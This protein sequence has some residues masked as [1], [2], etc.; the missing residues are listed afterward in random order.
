MQGDPLDVLPTELLASVLQVAPPTIT[1]LA[2]SVHRSTDGSTHVL[3][4]LKLT[5]QLDADKVDD[6]VVEGQEA[7][8]KLRWRKSAR[9]VLDRRGDFATVRPPEGVVPGKQ[10]AQ[11][12]ERERERAGMLALRHFP[13]SLRQWTNALELLSNHGAVV[14]AEGG[15]KQVE[16]EE[17]PVAGEAAE[18]ERLL[19]AALACG[20]ESESGVKCIRRRVEGASHALPFGWFLDEL[21]LELAAEKTAAA[22]IRDAEAAA[23]VAEEERKAD[24][25]RAKVVAEEEKV[26]KSEDVAAVLREKLERV[27][28]LVS[29]FSVPRPLRGP[30]QLRLSPVFRPSWIF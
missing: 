13:R 11:E 22:A 20:H 15:A 23:V 3:D 30:A 18:F 10:E 24:A 21:G 26:E 6:G 17:E 28:A 29:R 14:D 5:E 1:M 19:E 9:S 4:Q 12:K 7:K 8:A 2:G 25:E 27:A 16:G